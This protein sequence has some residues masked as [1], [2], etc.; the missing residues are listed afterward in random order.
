MHMSILKGQSGVGLVEVL[1][2]TTVFSIGVLGT[3]S[4][5]I[6]AKKANFEASQQSVA[7]HM[8]RDILARMR[9]NQK[10]IAS[11]VVEEVGAH[12]IPVETDCR[13]ESC[14]RGQLAAY[15][16]SEWTSL[17]IGEAETVSIN[18]NELQSGGLVLPRACIRSSSG[19]VSITIV[20]R[21]VGKLISDAS[22][23]CADS[24]GLYGPG[25]IQ[26]RLFVLTSFIGAL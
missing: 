3:F 4:M 7:T 11:Y 15:D 10:E 1:I 18:D 25:N 24:T 5:Q 12:A 19:K 14:S 26:R 16:L 20:W 17:L 22:S 21:G 6:S 23:N 13:L 9:S 8:A 2:A